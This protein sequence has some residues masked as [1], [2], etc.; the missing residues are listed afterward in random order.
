MLKVRESN[1]DLLR[2]ISAFAVIMLHVSGGFLVCNE[3]GIPTDCSL[4]VMLINHIVRFAVPCFLMLSGA[5]LLADERNAD[6]NFFYKKSIRNIGITGAVFFLLYTMYRVAK[7]VMGVF[8]LHIDSTDTFLASLFFIFKD[9]LQGRPSGHL[10]YLSVL[11]GLYLVVPFVIRLNADFSGGGVE[12]YGNITLIFLV[13]ASLGYVT[14]EHKL[15]WD[16]GYAFY[17]LSYFMMGYK[18][19]RWSDSHKDNGK[20]VL[21]IVS[22]F[23]INTVL[24]YINY[25]RGLEGLPVDTAKLWENPFSYGPL[26]PIEVIAACLVFAGFS[27]MKTKRD[28]SGLSGCTFLIY[29]VH[30]GV[31]DVI[32]VL[33]GDRLFGNP[34][35]EA[36]AVAII[37]VIVFVIS[38]LF[39]EVY[40]K[41]KR[42]FWSRR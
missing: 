6:Y 5:F 10:W 21:L 34:S 28:F 13:L 31:I 26:A 7:L 12:L 8:V 30:A 35:I 27:V 17:F 33:M 36:V 32:F 24:A 40:G 25:L 2:I 20:A 29:L 41:L 14:S 3:E 23:L 39:A 16:I 9:L 4:P 19:R 37:S 15:M 18:I 11:I 42:R 1:Y 38:L 22:G